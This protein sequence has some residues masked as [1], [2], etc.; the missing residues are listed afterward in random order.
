VRRW[1]PSRVAVLEG[2]FQD[3]VVV[4]YDLEFC[5]EYGEARASWLRAESKVVSA[6]DNCHGM[7]SQRTLNGAI[8][9]FC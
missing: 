9:A 1:S 5:R 2:H 3:A 6:E 4:A 8:P 7:P